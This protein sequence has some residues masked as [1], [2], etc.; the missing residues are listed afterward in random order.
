MGVYRPFLT[1]A[2]VFLFPIREPTTPLSAYLST[3]NFA[4]QSERRL[5]RR[6]LLQLCAGGG[7]AAVLAEGLVEPFTVETVTMEVALPHLPP[8]LD[9]LKVAQLT[10]PHRGNLTPDAV[11]R[12]AVRKAAAFEPDLVVLTGD[13]V[14]WDVADATPLA[15]MLAPLQPRLGMLGVLGNH[16]YL[17]PDAIARKLTD[18]AGVTMLRNGAHEVAPGL[19]TAGIEDTLKGVPDTKK[20]LKTVPE[21]AALLFLTHNPVGVRE[22][23]DR[24]CVALAGHTHGGQVR[25]PGFKP[26][27]PPGMEGFTQIDG[28]G[29]YGKARLYVSRGI[30][31]TAFPLRINCP[32]E[33]T[34]LT[35]R[36][37]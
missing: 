10:D 27:V 18:H 12:E 8:A 7:A 11:I 28:W 16:D 25:A 19:W 22:V 15:K 24:A 5:T 31:C 37:G 36:T 1:F 14:R 4:E 2:K 26:H 6:G 23:Q 9:G 20:A 13:Y 30:G 34:L 29:K 35:L 32:P 17:Y 33:L 3:M 21:D